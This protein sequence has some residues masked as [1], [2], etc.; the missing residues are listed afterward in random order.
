MLS[1]FLETSLK[2]NS[3]FFRCSS[4]FNTKYLLTVD[5]AQG[6]D[7]A[8]RAR[9]LQAAARLPKTGLLRPDAPAASAVPS[10]ECSRW[11]TSTAP[12]RPPFCTRSSRRRQPPPG[13]GA[14]C[15]C[16]ALTASAC[17]LCS[18]STRSACLSEAICVSDSAKDVD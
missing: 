17:S 10:R 3:G 18:L 15:A 4:N 16:H 6:P 1:L 11:R 7:S 13:G 9:T 5:Q 8:L 12:A 14:S 2:P